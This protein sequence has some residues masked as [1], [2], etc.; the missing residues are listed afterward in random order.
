ME[1]ENSA[2]RL[3]G[4]DP[5]LKWRIVASLLGEKVA[6]TIGNWI[7]DLRLWRNHVLTFNGRKDYALI[8]RFKDIHKGDRCVI[9]GNGPSLRNTNLDLL[10][11]E[12][13]FGLNR[14]YLMFEELGFATSYHVAVNELVVEQCAEELERLNVPLFTTIP[15]RKNL[16]NATNA[17]FLNPIGGPR[18]AENAAHGVWEGGTVTYVAMQIA[19]F[20]GF[21]EVIL[22]GVDHKFVDEGPANKTV[23]STGPDRNHFDSRYFGAGFRW[24]LPDLETSE[25]AYGLARRKFLQAGRTITDCTVGGALSIFPKSTLEDALS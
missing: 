7:V 4:Q 13:T 11:D 19:Y 6:F 5:S 17:V 1:E 14:I 24:Q 2:E 25:K 18:F 22:V 21:T 23:V 12:Y 8:R 10:R 15:N 3:G 16:S 9:I 20:M